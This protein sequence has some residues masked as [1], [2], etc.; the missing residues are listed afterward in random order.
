M[1]EYNIPPLEYEKTPEHPSYDQVV[2]K[3]L[4]SA[5]I[6]GLPVEEQ[7]HVIVDRFIGTLVRQGGVEGSQTSYSPADILHLMDEVSSDPDALQTIT[8]T[9]GLRSAVKLLAS[10]ERTGTLFG[11]FGQQLESSID[12]NGNEVPTLTSVAQIEGYLI[13]G[14][15]ENRVTNPTGGVHMEGDSWMPVIMSEV[16]RVQKNEYLKTLPARHELYDLMSSEAPLIKLSARDLNMAYS[17]A[18]K[19]G[20]DMDLLRRSTEMVKHRAKVGREIA[21]SAI[22]LAMRGRVDAYNTKADGYSMKF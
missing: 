11:H 14:G 10:D 1:T 2:E 22:V 4:N 9:D 18:E 8:R 5:D 15:K 17:S 6:D 12:H 16:E 13:A 20:V 19:V 3:L 21:S 7:G